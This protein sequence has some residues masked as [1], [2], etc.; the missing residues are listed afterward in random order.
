M[1]LNPALV[2]TALFYPKLMSL[3]NSCVVESRAFDSRVVW[4][5]TLSFRSMLLS[6]VLS[7]PPTWIVPFSLPALSNLRCVFV[8]F[9]PFL[10]RSHPF[11]RICVVH[12]PLATC[13]RH[14]TFHQ[15]PPGS[16][17]A[18]LVSLNQ[19]HRIHKSVEVTGLSV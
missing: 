19:K 13:S 7:N 16:K 10:F 6:S 17:L 8:V 14:Q 12:P 9:L 4:K 3:L 1:L 15:P 18:M 11:C 5:P 2:D